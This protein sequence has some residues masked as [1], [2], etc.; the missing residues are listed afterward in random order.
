MACSFN[1]ELFA[2][3]AAIITYIPSR[4]SKR[5]NRGYNQSE[6]LAKAISD[7]TP[8][9]AIE[10]LVKIGRTKEQTGLSKE[11]RVKNIKKAFRSVNIK[12]INRKRIILIDDVFTSGATMNE[13]AKTLTEAGAKEVIGMVVA[14]TINR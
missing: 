9:P 13:A 11:E 7:I 2:D 3:E 10:T 14:R 12:K 4:R 8:L 6:L 1:E 5:A